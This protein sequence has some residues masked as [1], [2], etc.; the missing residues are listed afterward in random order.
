MTPT[1]V[2]LK[3][4]VG[5]AAQLNDGLYSSH[6]LFISG[7]GGDSGLRVPSR[8]AHPREKAPAEGDQ[9]RQHGGHS[10]NRADGEIDAAGQNHKGHS[11]GQ[12]DVD[13]RLSDHVDQVVRREKTLGEESKENANNDEDR[14]HP[15]DLNE[16]AHD[17]FPRNGAYG[18]IL[19][20]RD[21]S[22]D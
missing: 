9:K 17:L 1:I 10:E 14:Q 6:G 18:S 20:R 16:V 8:V 4:A 22:H 13:R 7:E 19:G 5:I 11:S 21:S 2:P 3:S 15:C 12:D